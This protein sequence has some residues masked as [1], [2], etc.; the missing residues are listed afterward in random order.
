MAKHTV[1]TPPT[2]A[3]LFTFSA[4][5]LLSCRSALHAQASMSVLLGKA[6]MAA[7]TPS[8]APMLPALCRLSPL[9]E[10]SFKTKA[11]TKNCTC[12]RCTCR[13]PACKT[14]CKPFVA[15]AKSL[16][17]SCK[18]SPA[19]ASRS[20]QPRSCE[21]AS[22]MRDLIVARV[23]S[24]PWCSMARARGSGPSRQRRHNTSKAQAN[25]WMDAGGRSK[26][27]SATSRPPSSTI[28]AR[29]AAQP[30]RAAS[31]C[32][33]MNPATCTR[34]SSALAR[35]VWRTSGS[36]PNSTICAWL[37]GKSRPKE[38]RVEQT[39]T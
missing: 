35:S 20:T 26:A 6:R 30:S 25:T 19:K 23:S 37:S 7:K 22:S 27:S 33:R 5:R 9:S 28:C 11:Q 29:T 17:R 34:S 14:D 12:L 36:A 1:L 21:S 15:C 4:Q 8:Q 31:C 3:I 10:A 13:A 18:L 32:M 39:T 38:H 24:K 2:A 16:A